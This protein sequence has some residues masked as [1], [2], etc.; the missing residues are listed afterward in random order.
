VEGELRG[1]LAYDIGGLVKL[2][3]TRGVYDVGRTRNTTAKLPL[4]VS[5]AP[6]YSSSSF[7]RRVDSIVGCSMA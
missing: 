1:C 2:A 5:R 3:P 6:A 4:Q 7:E